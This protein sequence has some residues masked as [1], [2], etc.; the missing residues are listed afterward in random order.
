[1]YLI[2]R[3]SENNTPEYIGAYH[4]RE[5]QEHYPWVISVHTTVH[6]STIEETKAWIN[7][8]ENS[9]PNF[10]GDHNMKIEDYII[11]KTYIATVPLTDAEIEA[12]ETKERMYMDFRF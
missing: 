9:I 8:I 12:A 10:H 2:G 1:M 11:F 4:V 7:S 3:M 5:T 6:F